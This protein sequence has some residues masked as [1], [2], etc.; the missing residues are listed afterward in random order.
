MWKPIR[1][2]DGCESTRTCWGQRSIHRA[3]I[4]RVQIVECEILKTLVNL[5][6]PFKL[7]YASFSLSDKPDVPPTSLTGTVSEG[8]S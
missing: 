3:L 7:A 1:L 5:A 8:D 6:P 2:F 4:V